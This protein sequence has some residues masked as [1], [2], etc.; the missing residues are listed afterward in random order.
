MTSLSVFICISGYQEPVGAVY[1]VIHGEY[2][3]I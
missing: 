3:E 1:F 2:K